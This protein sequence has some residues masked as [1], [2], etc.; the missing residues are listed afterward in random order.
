[1]YR[2]VVKWY[3]TKS[4]QSAAVCCFFR[5]E[6]LWLY[7]F[8]RENGHDKATGQTE[9][10]YFLDYSWGQRHCWIY[11]IQLRAPPSPVYNMPN[12]PKW[13]SFIISDPHY[14]PFFS[15][16]IISTV[17]DPF[18]IA[19][20]HNSGILKQFITASGRFVKNS[21]VLHEL[22]IKFNKASVEFTYS[23]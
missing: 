6:P 23:N 4:Q 16:W 8:V 5:A 12:L 19:L 9:C 13:L 7:S 10:I 1:M 3:R 2:S 18:S 21:L 14:I 17:L 22:T 11:W 20:E 15:L